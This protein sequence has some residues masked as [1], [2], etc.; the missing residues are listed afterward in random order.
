GALRRRTL[1]A[2]LPLD[3]G[4]RRLGRGG[5]QGGAQ[6]GAQGGG[7]LGDVGG[8]RMGGTGGDA[9]RSGGRWG[10]GA[11]LGPHDQP[12]VGLTPGVEDEHGSI[13]SWQAGGARGTGIHRRT[14]RSARWPRLA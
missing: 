1:A 13:R 8:E 9:A 11:V 4:G 2:G 7:Q 12:F 10:S 3:V 14:D 5:G 6:G